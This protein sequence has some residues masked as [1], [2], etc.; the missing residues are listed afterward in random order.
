MH[1]PPTEPRRRNPRRRAIYLNDTVYCKNI[2]EAVWRYT[3]G[4]Y[5]VIKKWLSYPEKSVLGRNLKTDEALY[6]QQMARRI[7]AII[8]LRRR[9]G[10]ELRSRQGRNRPA[11]HRHRP[12]VV[13]IQRLAAEKD[14]DR[15]SRYCRT[16]EAKK[17]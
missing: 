7:A 1:P 2:P 17:Q 8:L 16:R 13:R 4:G 12:G 10:Q 11:I 3:L 9:I 5:Q 6:V 14:G 15:I